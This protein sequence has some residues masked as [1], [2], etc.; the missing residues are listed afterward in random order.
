MPLI[1]SPTIFVLFKS[2]SGIAE[3]ADVWKR[4]LQLKSKILWRHIK[5][6]RM[7]KDN[8]YLQ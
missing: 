8:K 1:K 2:R 4:T 7:M 6:S 3:T 5:L